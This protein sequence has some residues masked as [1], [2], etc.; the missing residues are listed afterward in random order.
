MS[1]NT[2]LGR[3]AGGSTKP[4]KMR[5][6]SLSKDSAVRLKTVVSGEEKQSPL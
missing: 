3:M 4:G 2:C 5:R 1:C 6:E